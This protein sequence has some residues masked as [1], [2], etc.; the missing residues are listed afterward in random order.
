MNR[1]RIAGVVFDFDGTLVDSMPLHFEA[2]RRVLAAGGV[3]LAREEFFG[4]IGG[5]A[6]ETIPKLLR[7][8]TC[9]FTVDEIHAR[10]KATLAQLL[11]TEPLVVLETSKLVPVFKAF[12][13]VGVAS[14]GARPGIEQ[15]LARLGWTSWFDVVI[16]GEDAQRGKPAPDLFLA[17]AH[18]MGVDPTRCLA[19][20]DTDD[21]VA[22][23]RAA[24]M[25]VFDVRQAHASVP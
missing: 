10:K 24:G 20:E 2:Y 18:G 21:G 12:V 25:D 4:A 23:A 22:A 9:T 16:T 19:F 6:R 11:V 3:A 14:S 15:M 17:C 1:A 7:G 5:T 8:R 13:P